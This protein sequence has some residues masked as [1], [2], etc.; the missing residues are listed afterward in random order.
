MIFYLNSTTQEKDF[1]PTLDSH[2]AVTTILLLSRIGL[3]SLMSKLTFRKN[4][5]GTKEWLTHLNTLIRCIKNWILISVSKLVFL[6]TFVCL[7]LQIRY[8]ERSTTWDCLKEH[9]LIRD[10]VP[11]L[12]ISLLIQSSTQVEVTTK[13]KKASLIFKFKKTVRHAVIY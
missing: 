13:T 3:E 6:L 8:S 7:N 2:L 5:S 4:S 9:R 11:R 12:R 1:S 10:T